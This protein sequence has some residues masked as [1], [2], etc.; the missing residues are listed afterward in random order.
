MSLAMVRRN[1]LLLGSLGTPQVPLSFEIYL[2][3][4]GGVVREGL[5]P[6][7]ALLSPTATVVTS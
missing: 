6:C 5:I 3:F 4:Q 7:T 1:N 2:G